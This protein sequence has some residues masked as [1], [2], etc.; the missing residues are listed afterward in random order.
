MPRKRITA[1]WPVYSFRIEP[2]LRAQLE[3]EANYRQLQVSELVRRTL[4]ERYQTATKEN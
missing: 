3:R 2:G 4:A 1:G